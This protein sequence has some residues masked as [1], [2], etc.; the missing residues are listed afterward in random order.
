VLACIL[1][2]AARPTVARFWSAEENKIRCGWR[3]ASLLIGPGRRRMIEER[4]DRA[5]TVRRGERLIEPP[6]AL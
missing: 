4:V 5:W 2:I 1:S 3:Q 6:V